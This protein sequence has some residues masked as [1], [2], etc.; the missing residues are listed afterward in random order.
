MRYGGIGIILGILGNHPFVHFDII[1]RNFN[2]I[3]V[4]GYGPENMGFID[5]IRIGKL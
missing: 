1:T 3:H 5:V 4:N 2:R